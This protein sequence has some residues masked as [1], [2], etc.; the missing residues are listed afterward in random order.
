[1]GLK[2]FIM[3]TPF[4]GILMFRKKINVVLDAFHTSGVTEVTKLYGFI[5]P[6]PI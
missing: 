5:L 2:H 4:T 3:H 1:M 6:S